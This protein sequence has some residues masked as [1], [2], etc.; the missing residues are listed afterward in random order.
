M[1]K[2]DVI[3]ALRKMNDIAAGYS[4]KDIFLGFPRN[5]FI[6]VIYNAILMLISKEGV[7]KCKDCVYAD[8]AQD[9]KCICEAY[10]WDDKTRVHEADWFCGEGRSKYG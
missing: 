5:A 3:K 6:K 7:I 8:D 2:E 1:Y 4:S 10:V 9:E